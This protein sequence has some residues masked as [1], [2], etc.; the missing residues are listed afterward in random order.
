M[1][2]DDG[3]STCKSN[4][5]RQRDCVN[6]QRLVALG[7]MTN[8]T[9][10]VISN[11]SLGGILTYT[12]HSLTS[13][14]KPFGPAKDLS[15]SSVASSNCACNLI[16][17]L[18]GLTSPFLKKYIIIRYATGVWSFVFPCFY[19]GTKQET[20]QPCRVVPLDFFLH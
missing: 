2:C 3:V 7:K 20:W 1:S 10:I 12:F 19:R 9:D 5:H 6:S 11:F 13:A 4:A 17:K 14:R 18:D 16:K 15:P 8:C